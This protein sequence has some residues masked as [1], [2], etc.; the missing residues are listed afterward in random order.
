VGRRAVPMGVLRR[1]QDRRD[2]VRAGDVL[3][4]LW[5]PA[6]TRYPQVGNNPGNLVSDKPSTPEAT[7]ERHLSNIC[8]KIGVASR[9]EAARKALRENWITIEE[10][11]R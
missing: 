11:N 6:R 2:L 8:P 4:R 3:P 7:V 10:I 5:R 9:G 1:P